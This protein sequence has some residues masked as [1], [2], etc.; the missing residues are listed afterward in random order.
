MDGWTTEEVDQLIGIV[1]SNAVLYHQS[2]A[3]YSNRNTID[4]AWRSVS[5]KFNNKS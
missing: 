5:L 3:G 1:R 2:L 4:L